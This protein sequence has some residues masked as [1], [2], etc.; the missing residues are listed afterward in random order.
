M[1]LIS[2][3]GV[4]EE[5]YNALELKYNKL[6]SE[7]K[8][9]MK[10][11][12]ECKNG[13]SNLIARIE[14]ANKDKKY[15]DAVKN[16]NILYERFPESPKN[17]QY[18][19]LLR[20]LEKKILVQQKR[21][22][23][24]RLAEKK[25]QE[26]E[27]KEKRLIANLNKTGMWN[28]NFYVD[29]FGEPTKSGYITNTS[30]IRGIFSNS[31][32]QDSKLDVKFLISNASDIS[33]I[34]FEYAGNNPVKGYSRDKYQILMQDKNGKRYKLYA[35]NYSDRLRCNSSDSKKIHKALMKGGNIKFKIIDINTP[36][37][38]YSF[39]IGNAEWYNN[40]YRKLSKK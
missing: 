12:D 19:K 25:K 23:K 3:C 8:I 6:I 9:L 15:T 16:I 14:K 2:G 21:M 29:D 28:V 33:L 10:N 7:K 17:K 37:T 35:K 4:P 5:K 24:K 18:Q 22:K 31:A 27:A 39:S 11:L 1:I 36:T 26:R 13:S 30:L 40:A 34:L 38:E 32:T 20:K